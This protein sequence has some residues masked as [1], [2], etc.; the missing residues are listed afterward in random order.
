MKPARFE[1]ERPASV[2]EAIA[3]LGRADQDAKVLAG[4]QSLIPMMNLRIV[5][6]ERLIDIGRIESLRSIQ[7][8]SGELRIGSMVTHNTILSSPAVAKVCPLLIEAYHHVAHHSV[9]N[10]GT[11]GGSLCHNDPGAEMPLIVS[12]LG[13]TLVARSTKGE[14]LIAADDFFRG[15]FATALQPNELLLEIR[16]PLPP[17]GHGYAFL[18]V[19]QRKGD[20]ALVACAAMLTIEGDTCRNVR[21]GYRSIGSDSARFQSIEALLEGRRPT[22]E[23]FAQV[24]A[25]A[26]EAVNPTADVHADIAFRRDLV[27]TLTRRVL[28]TAAERASRR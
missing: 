24:A 8:V 20:F 18:E 27:R 10:R 22:P 4:G 26:S 19:S 28:T 16:I 3:A 12:I 2:E 17:A 9:R 14:R 23:L 15:S 7:E 25:T 11:F 1:Y 5:K 21:A 6:T 13:A